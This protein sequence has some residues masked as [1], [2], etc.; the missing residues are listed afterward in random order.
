MAMNRR[1]FLRSSAAAGLISLGGVPPTFLCRAALANESAAANSGASILV[2]LQLE[3][4]NDGLN[5]V[6]PYA[7]EEYYK[8]RPGIG[9][10]RDAVLR[11]DDA[12]GFHPQLAGFKELYDEGMLAILQGIG[13]PQQDRSHFRSMDIWQSASLDVAAPDRGWVGRALDLAAE[14]IASETPALALGVERLPLALT[15]ANTNVPMIADIDGFRLN[16]GSDVRGGRS[17]RD[18]MRR[19]ADP[20]SGA[21]SG[22]P[23]TT[24]ADA[25]LLFLQRAATSAYR[26]AERLSEV[27]REYRPTATYPDSQ[28][29]NQL[30]LIAQMIGG[31]LGTRIFFVSLG[32]FDTHSQ[33]PGAH[34]AL[35]AELAAAVRAFYNDLKGH[36]L[37]ERVLLATYSEFGRRVKENG[38]LGTDHGAASQMFIITPGKGGLYG[39]H[40]SLTDLDD[41]DLKFHTDFRSVYAT[42]LEK[43]LGF[44]AEP[45]LGGRFAMM[46]FV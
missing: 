39:A 1:T 5:T 33:Q 16:T 3:G 23:R 2:I 36:G 20:S 41:G 40:P 24:R 37:A 26:T 7:D 17:R 22:D 19:L 38:S 21:G 10:P 18:L 42:L 43:W 13:Y 30:K 28:L 44:A 8:A 25:Q 6:I 31:E 12:L 29:A 45:V 11:L 4:G 27:T 46:D 15:A 34:Q 9:I 14:R 35:L 32:G